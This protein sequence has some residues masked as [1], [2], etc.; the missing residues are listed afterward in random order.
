MLAS[1]ALHLRLSFI[2]LSLLAASFYPAQGSPKALSP[3]DKILLTATEA[4]ESSFFTIETTQ[5]GLKV[6][7]KVIYRA[8]FVSGDGL[9]VA[10]LQAF[11]TGSF[12]AKTIDGKTKVVVQGVVAAAPKAGYAI[13]QTDQKPS[14]FLRLSK[15]PLSK[16]D[17]LGIFRQKEHGGAL[18]APVLSRRETTLARSR[19]YVEI[20]SLGANLGERGA[21]HAPAGTPL[22]DHLGDAAGIL[23]APSHSLGQRLLLA[24]PAA[25]LTTKTSST[26]KLVPF[27][28]P[29]A[30]RPA[31]PLAVNPTYIRG[32]HAQLTGQLRSAEKLLRQAIAQEPKS[33]VAWQRLGF[34]LRDLERNEEAMAAFDQASAHGN[35]LGSF[36]LN[37]ADQFRQ[38]GEMES[39]L[40]VLKKAVTAAPQDYDLHRAYALALLLNKERAQAEKQLRTAISLAPEVIACWELLSKCLGAQGKWDQEKIASDKIYELEALYRPR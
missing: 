13:V 31:D 37:R 14:K 12:V 19:K 27:P 8:F 5:P 26:A 22:I 36:E 18:L 29:A 3:G 9:A 16:G 23:M 35:K 34:I 40:S 10:P 20:L 21:L 33:A 7:N 25:V 39:A 38:Q 11:D 4:S 17:K 32:R 28:L 6:E 2:A 15:R 24:L 30:L 1:G